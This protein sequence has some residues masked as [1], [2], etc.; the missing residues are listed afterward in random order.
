MKLSYKAILNSERCVK[1]NSLDDLDIFK[2]VNILDKIDKG[3][4]SLF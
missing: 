2:H 4:C 1:R 3:L